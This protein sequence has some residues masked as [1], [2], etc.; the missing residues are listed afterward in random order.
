MTLSS[1]DPGVPHPP[2][3][4]SWIWDLQI[5]TKLDLGP[6]FASLFEF[7]MLEGCPALEGIGVCHDVQCCSL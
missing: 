4:W 2:C 1:V 7:R 3:Y 5:L 6:G